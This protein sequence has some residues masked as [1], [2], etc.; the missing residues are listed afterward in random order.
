MESTVTR[1]EIDDENEPQYLEE[2]EDAEETMRRS[3]ITRKGSKMN[4][5]SAGAHA[6]RY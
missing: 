6:D 5:T 1:K 3:A 4:K 2:D